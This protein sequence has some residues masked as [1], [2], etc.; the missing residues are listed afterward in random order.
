MKIVFRVA[1]EGLLNKLVSWW[2]TPLRYKLGKEYLSGASHVELKFD[3]DLCYSASQSENKVR[4]KVIKADAPKWRTYELEVTDEQ[5][6][7]CEEWL[8]YRMGKKY[9]YL[10]IFGFVSM[11][12]I[13]DN[14]SR[15]FCSELCFECLRVNTDL[16]K[17]FTF[18]DAATVSPN[19]LESIIKCSTKS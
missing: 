6:T 1:N 18:V 7:R 16:L 13:S 2:T 4:A 15:W 11:F 12:K 8:K 5:R 14:P 19:K 10:G 9:D 17:H 3:N